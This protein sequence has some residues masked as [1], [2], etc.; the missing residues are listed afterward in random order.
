MPLPGL[1]FVPVTDELARGPLRPFATQLLPKPFGARASQ[2]RRELYGGP[3]RPEGEQAEKLAPI[4]SQRLGSQACPF[5]LSGPGFRSEGSCLLTGGSPKGVHRLVDQRIPRALSDPGTV[6]RW[7]ERLD[8]RA[9]SKVVLLVPASVKLVEAFGLNRVV[10]VA[11]RLAAH[12]VDRYYIHHPR[13]LDE[14]VRSTVKCRRKA[15]GAGCG[16]WPSPGR[17][18]KGHC[19]SSA[20]LR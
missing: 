16:S 14:M 4:E 2:L 19:C 17:R 9:L 11:D 18:R 1:G 20:R 5:T 15:G 10:E 6:R 3:T 7:A 13:P 8:K 12:Q